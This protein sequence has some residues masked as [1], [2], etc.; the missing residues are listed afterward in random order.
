MPNILGTRLR[1]SREKLGLTQDSLANAVHLSAEF[2]SNLELG[3]RAPSLETLNSLAGFFQEDVAYFLEA[4]ETAKEKLFELGEKDKNVK[5]GMI[6]FYNTC[7][8]F[9]ELEAALGLRPELAPLYSMASA[10]DIASNERDRMGLGTE[11]VKNVFSLFDRHGLHIIRQSLPKDSN[12][13]GIFIFFEL[14]QTA[15]VL[16]NNIHNIDHQVFIA[17]HEYFHYLKDR[18]VLVI[19]D[20]HDV[21]VNEYVPLYHPREKLAF[22]FSLNFLMPR[23][24]IE[25]IIRLQ[26]QSRRLKFQDVLYLKRYFGVSTMAV[27]YA[28][29]NYDCL[30]S[31]KFKE[32][33]K[34]ETSGNEN[35]VPD[36][37]A[38]KELVSDRLKWMVLEAL[39][40]KKINLEKASRLLKMKKT[41]LLK[42]TRK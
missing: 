31:A 19:A 17:V 2:I 38:G 22:T 40:K 10:E 3:K 27:L 8:E 11:P 24:K 23:K 4:K 16:I 37:H 42:L 18:N 35:D 7:R 15:F 13:S 12:I 29:Y 32:F 41:V 21:F 1:I 30:S 26:F 33:Q 34:K 39:Q 6:E 28:L 5:T 14:E 36:A 20:N 25:D 9:I